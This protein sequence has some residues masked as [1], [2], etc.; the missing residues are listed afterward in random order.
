MRFI[1][2]RE[3]GEKLAA[4]MT[5][6]HLVR[7]L[8]LAIPP[9]GARIGWEIARRLRAPMDVLV[10]DSVEIPGR[11][12]A[13]VGYVVDGEFFPDG[14]ACR[15]QGVTTGYAAILAAVVKRAELTWEDTLRSHERPLD[16]QG[17]SIILV[18]DCPLD[19]GR[20]RTAQAAL[21]VRGVGTIIYACLFDCPGFESVVPPIHTITL[22]RPDERRSVMLVNTGYQ[23]TTDDEIAEL[24]AQSRH[25]SGRPAL[26]DH[27]EID[28]D[29][30]P[31][32]SVEVTACRQ[33]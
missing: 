20:L 24:L 26:P 28:Y 17:R 1:D 31:A 9:A 10:V 29:S 4:Q 3:A 23:Q 19:A 21:L 14:V 12:H 5:R 30:V 32:A 25:R 22:F 11:T 16:V 33:S 13:T 27:L 2:H 8:V 18:S 15:Q 6:L 7:P